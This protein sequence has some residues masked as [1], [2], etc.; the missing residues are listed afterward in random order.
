MNITLKRKVI[1]KKHQLPV[2]LQERELDL[3][4]LVIDSQDRLLRGFRDQTD[5]EDD[6]DYMTA[7]NLWVRDLNGFIKFLK[8]L[9]AEHQAFGT[10]H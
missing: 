6:N 8:T 3:S 5:N 4:A 7:R 10:I 9:I 2:E 1:Y